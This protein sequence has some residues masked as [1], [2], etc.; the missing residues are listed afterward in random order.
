M[1]DGCSTCGTLLSELT[2]QQVGRML[3]QV[4]M[5][6]WSVSKAG[7]KE[8]IQGLGEVE[9]VYNSYD[10]NVEGRQLFVWKTRVGHVKMSGS[11]DSYDD[12]DWNY[13]YKFTAPET[14]TITVYN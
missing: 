1:S 8:T 3:A 9:V 5:W 2:I 6:K 7:Y 11:F 14:K 10:Q 4:D 13:D 12:L